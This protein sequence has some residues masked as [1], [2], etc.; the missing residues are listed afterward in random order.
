MNDKTL[1]IFIGF[2]HR[3]PVSLSVLAQSIYTYSKT[4]V[5]ITPLVYNQLPMTR[6]DGL[7]PF[8]WSRFLVPYLCDYR[9]W[10][11]FLDLDM[12][13]R[14]DITKLFDLAD[15][16]YAVMVAKNPKKFEWASVM[17]FNCGHPANKVLT[18]DYVNEAKGLHGINWCKPEEIGGIPA[19]WNHLVGYD[20]PRSDAKLIH[21]TQGVPCFPETN[22][23][24]GADEWFKEHKF[25]NHAR[26]WEELMGNS[27]H[28][29]QLQDGTK[30]PKYK[31]EAPA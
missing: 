13:V 30:V 12:L 29:V 7:T 9:G 23:S 11:L 22:D 19:E 25:M 14:D 15:E 6:K 31:V 18:P 24:E 10:A 21:Y 27:V 16:K 26:P 8:T 3:Q 5:A 2:D 1:K 4:P 17:L 28:A 20:K